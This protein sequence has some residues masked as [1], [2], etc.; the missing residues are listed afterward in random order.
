MPSAPPTR[1][2]TPRVASPSDPAVAP[3]ERA[4]LNIRA[5]PVSFATVGKQ[6][7]QTPFTL[8]LPPGTHNVFFQNDLLNLRSNAVVTVRAGQTYTVFVDFTKPSP[9]ITGN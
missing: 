9:S 2:A 6:R 3:S 4:T 1:S 5:N 7:G 8:M